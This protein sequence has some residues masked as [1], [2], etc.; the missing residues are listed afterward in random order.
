MNEASTAGISRH[1]ALDSIYMKESYQ[2]LQAV[3]IP[4][5]FKY[6]PFKINKRLQFYGYAFFTPIVRHIKAQATESLNGGSAMR[7]DLYSELLPV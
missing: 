6:T 4:L 3:A 7:K 1:V 5:T 2:R